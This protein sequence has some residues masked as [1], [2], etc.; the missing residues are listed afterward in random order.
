MHSRAALGLGVDAIVRQIGLDATSRLPLVGPLAHASV[1]TTAL[2][3]LRAG[4]AAARRRAADDEQGS[5]MRQL[6]ANVLS[7]STATLLAIAAAAELPIARVVAVGARELGRA[8]GRISRRRASRARSTPAR[9]CASRP[10]RA[11]RRGARCRRRAALDGDVVEARAPT[12]MLGYLD[13]AAATAAAFVERDGK[14]WVR[15]RDVDRVDA[16]ALERAIAATPGV[17]EAAVL[18]V[19]RRARRAAH[20]L[21]RRR[22]QRRA[23]AAG[24]RGH[25]RVAAAPRRRQHRSRGAAPHGQHRLT[26]RVAPS[27]GSTGVARRRHMARA[28]DLRYTTD[29]ALVFEQLFDP[30]SSTYTYLVG[31]DET[32]VAALIDP[33][34]RAGGARSRARRAR[35]A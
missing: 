34:A 5:A 13:D 17:R 24:A 7:G 26:Y 6:G 21:R 16:A 8:G 22:R 32:K 2:A 12:A 30:E 20:R 10:P 25:A 11:T 29:M 9:R 3:T 19:R 27:R 18:A 31:D 4:G 14:R 28:R 33:V 15:A 35:T 23:A 1:L